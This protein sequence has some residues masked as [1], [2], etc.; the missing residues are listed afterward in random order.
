MKVSPYPPANQELRT[1]FAEFSTPL[2][3]D[4]CVRFKV[5]LRIAPPEFGR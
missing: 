3:A 1:A 2:L 5:S 4:A